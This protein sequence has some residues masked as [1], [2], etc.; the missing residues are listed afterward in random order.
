MRAT[1]VA[2]ATGRAAGAPATLCAVWSDTSAASSASSAVAGQASAFRDGGC[3]GGTGDAGAAEEAVPVKIGE[4]PDPKSGVISTGSGDHAPGRTSTM[5][6]RNDDAALAAADVALAAAALALATAGVP[7]ATAAVGVAGEAAAAITAAPARCPFPLAVRRASESRVARSFLTPFV[8]RLRSSSAAF[9]AG[10]FIPPTS[11]AVSDAIL[12]RRSR[13][14]APV[15]CKPVEARS[16]GA[17]DCEENTSVRSENER[18]PRYTINATP[19]ASGGAALRKTANR[20][21]SFPPPR[22]RAVGRQ[23]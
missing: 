16:N 18:E 14:A 11:S 19:C 23:K 9:S 5:R 21:C 10:T 3:G 17:S 15:V 2:L 22:G 13:G 6:L 4:G 12:V 20:T 8:S 1:S 7:D